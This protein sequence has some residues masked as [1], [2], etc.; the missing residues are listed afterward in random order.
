MLWTPVTGDG[1]VVISDGITPSGI[2]TVILD[3]RSGS[4]T[5]TLGL[6]DDQGDFFAF[7]DGLMSGSSAYVRHGIREI[8]VASITGNTG[9]WR[10]GYTSGHNDA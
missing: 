4:G 1:E 3:T 5:V 2:G 6:H 7:E 10:I 8:L 9:S